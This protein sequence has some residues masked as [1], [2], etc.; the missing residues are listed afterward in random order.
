[1]AA[2]L[3]LLGMAVGAA[4]LERDAQIQQMEVRR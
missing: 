3:C 1:M 4:V 2:L